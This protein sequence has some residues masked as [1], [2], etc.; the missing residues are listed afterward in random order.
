M[1]E[2]TKKAAMDGEAKKKMKDKEKDKRKEECEVEG[3]TSQGN[4]TC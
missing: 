3:R 2:G 4:F 1:K